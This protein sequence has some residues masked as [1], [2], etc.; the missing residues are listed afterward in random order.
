MHVHVPVLVLWLAV[1]EVA[2]GLSLHVSVVPLAR[3]VVGDR[4]RSLA[5][6]LEQKVKRLAGALAGR[7]ECNLDV[8]RVEELCEGS[9]R[10]RGE[11]RSTI[12]GCE[13]DGDRTPVGRVQLTSGTNNLRS[14][15]TDDIFSMLSQ[16]NVSQPAAVES[17]RVV[18]NEDQERGG[19]G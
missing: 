2:C 1:P 12:V 8:I 4:V 3:V 19:T 5:V 18:V 11:L 17:V 16:R 6:L 9:R 15:L 7:D 10:G 14:K 13:A